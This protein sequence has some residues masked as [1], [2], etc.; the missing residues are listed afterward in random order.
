MKTLDGFYLLGPNKY[1]EKSYAEALNLL[2]GMENPSWWVPLKGDWKL[3]AGEIN[4]KKTL[5]EKEKS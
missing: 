2:K 4:W 5:L 3:I 1:R